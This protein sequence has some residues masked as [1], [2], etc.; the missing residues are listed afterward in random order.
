VKGRDRDLPITRRPRAPAVLI[1]DDEDPLR[2]ALRRFLK[3]LGYRV[4][5]AASAEEALRIVIS[6]KEAV[7]L[8]ITDIYLSGMDGPE[9][10]RELRAQVGPIAV[11]YMSGG[12]ARQRLRP[13]DHFMEKPFGLDALKQRV[14][15]LLSSSD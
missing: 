15:Q 1:V 10:A 6:E 2:T 7:D 5:E 14:E 12:D 3:S 13:D 8:L 4:F 11:L 9:L